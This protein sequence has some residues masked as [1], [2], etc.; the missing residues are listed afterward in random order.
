MGFFL[1]SILGVLVLEIGDKSVTGSDNQQ[2][3]GSTDGL[4]DD[5]ALTEEEL[6]LLDSWMAEPVAAISVDP[7]PVDPLSTTEAIET[8]IEVI[9]DERTRLDSESSKFSDPAL[10]DSGLSDPELSN[11]D[12]LSWD[13]V[14]TLEN[15][16]S[17][18][19]IAPPPL[20]ETST[21]IDISEVEPPTPAIPEAS[22]P[23]V[24]IPEIDTP[25]DNPAEERDDALT[26]PQ[27]RTSLQDLTQDLRELQHALLLQLTD[28]V[29]RLGAEKARL[30]IDIDRLQ[31]YR[32]RL[33]EQ[34]DGAIAPSTSL[35]AALDP[36]AKEWAQRWAQQLA[37][38]M[39][40]YLNEALQEQK[41]TRDFTRDFTRDRPIDNQ[42]LDL[43]SL[44]STDQMLANLDYRVQAV[45]QG[46]QRDLDTYESDL[47]QR[48]NR[49]HDLQQQG[50]LVL[51]D[52]VHR[53]EVMWVQTSEASEASEAADRAQNVP[54][55]LPP[56]SPIPAPPPSR[57]IVPIPTTDKLLSG[58]GLG[59]LSV[60][61]LALFNGA[62][63]FLF[64][65]AGVVWWS[66][67]D[68]L[69]AI[70]PPTG[71]NILLVLA[72][73]TLAVL[74]IFPFVAK[75]MY[76]Q[77]WSDLQ[78]ALQRNKPIL[79]GK[80]PDP[81]PENWRSPWWLPITLSGIWLF[82]AQ[83]LGYF[84]I[85]HLPLG[86]AIALFFSYPVIQLFLGWLLGTERQS[87]MRWLLGAIVIAGLIMIIPDGTTLNTAWSGNLMDPNLGP[88]L[89]GVLCGLGSG[90]AFAGY[91][92]SSAQ[93]LKHLHPVPFTVLT[94][95]AVFILSA[96]GLI[97]QPGDWAAIQLAPTALSGLIIGAAI[98]GLL[99]LVSYGMN[100]GAVG[101]IGPSLT[102]VTGAASPLINGLLGW[103]LLGES[104]D[105]RPNVGIGLV[106]LGA[107]ALSLSR[108]RDRPS[109]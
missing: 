15:A 80:S 35:E 11:L 8:I 91:L 105:A 43:S 14:T 75:L 95:S 64:Q 42:A 41:Q 6:Q 72:L 40:Q 106:T 37:Q 50:E 67:G 17:N 56:R 76:P 58:L 59:I 44:D 68:P 26:P 97:V 82:L 96:L 13:I 51:Q 3:M 88:T 38:H 86:V 66:D 2:P 10:S 57:A 36:N 79:S 12:D 55:N 108:F 27:S 24:D 60:I 16:D 107:I 39:G 92:A 84:A 104:L 69:P 25:I 32:Q 21:T 109:P 48:L 47:V 61:T 1:G 63:K 46:L 7:E 87:P 52:L 5:A 18:P 22:I 71:G 90:F 70:L 54:P 62:L 20:T 85:A 34:Q 30:A 78:W 65:G 81:S 29:Q 49:M 89:T 99:S 93:S 102:A 74:L 33:E 77:V 94:F 19:P 103:I 100:N 98:L 4:V 53:L 28:D 45:L 31:L 73:R 83:L 23:A 9:D 101:K